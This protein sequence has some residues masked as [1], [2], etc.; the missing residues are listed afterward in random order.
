MEPTDTCEHCFGNSIPFI[1]SKDKVV[2]INLSD[3]RD[4]GINM[5]ELFWSTYHHR[6]YLFKEEEGPNWSFSMRNVFTTKSEG[7]RTNVKN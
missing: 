2:Y 1:S 5:M 7:G 3:Y 4:R 6:G